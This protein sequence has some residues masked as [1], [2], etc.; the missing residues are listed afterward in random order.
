[1]KDTEVAVTWNESRR[2]KKKKT[3]TTWTMRV[4]KSRCPR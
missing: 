1:M 4:S 3:T 2:M